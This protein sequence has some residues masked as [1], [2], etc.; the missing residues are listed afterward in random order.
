MRIPQAQLSE[1]SKATV[2][3]ILKASKKRTTVCQQMQMANYYAYLHSK[4]QLAK[5]TEN[6]AKLALGF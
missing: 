6:Y 2:K 4:Q 5:D 1:A 3:K